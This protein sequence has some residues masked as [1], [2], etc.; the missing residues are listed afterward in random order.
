MSISRAVFLNRTNPSRI[1]SVSLARTALPYAS[2]L[3]LTC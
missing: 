1:Q 2:T 3:N